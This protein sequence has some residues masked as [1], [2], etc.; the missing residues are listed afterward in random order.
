MRKILIVDDK[1]D[2]RQ[3]VRVTLEMEEVEF[4]EADSGVQGLALAQAEL[5]HL[6]ILDVMMPGAL[7]GFQVCEQL[8]RDLSTKAIVI[9]LLTARGQDA[10]RK[11]AQEVGANA[12]LIKP[13]SPRELLDVVYSVFENK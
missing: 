12:H 11:R 10:D 2:V 8:K 1:A 4:L 3:L 9:I 13:F 5:P 6:I 7:D